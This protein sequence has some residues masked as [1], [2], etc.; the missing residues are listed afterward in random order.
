MTLLI[1]SGSVS[2]RSRIFVTYLHAP[3][4]LIIVQHL[5]HHLSQILRIPKS[6]V[7]LQ[8]LSRFMP[9]SLAISR[10][11]SGRSPRTKCLTRSTLASVLVVEGLPLLGLSSTS[12]RPSLN[13]LC[14]SKTRERDI[15]SSSYICCSSLSASAGVF[16]SRTR[17]IRLVRCSVP[18]T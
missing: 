5:R 1:K 8:I 14:H 3:L 18:I 9:S 7:I 15:I 16:P 11:V 17:N 12:S 2:R 4:F 6:S 10:T 13:L